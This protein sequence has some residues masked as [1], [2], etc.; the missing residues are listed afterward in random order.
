ML[1]SIYPLTH[2]F[3]YVSF[4]Y[5]PV[6]ILLILFA[7]FGPYF[8]MI[9]YISFPLYTF[10]FIIFSMFTFHHAP[11][12]LMWSRTIYSYFVYIFTQESSSI[13]PLSW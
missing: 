11:Q 2:I 9:R 3:L 4:F 8:Y 6:Y 7:Y 13:M 5:I 10:I 1:R 12:C